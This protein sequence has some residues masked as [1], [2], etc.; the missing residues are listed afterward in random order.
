[1]FS[2]ALAVSAWGA[3]VRDLSGFMGHAQR[4][5]FYLSPTLYG[6]ELVQERFGKGA[7]AGSGLVAYLPEKTRVQMAQAE[8]AEAAAA[9]A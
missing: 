5:L 1:M 4:I 8:A 3:L 6:V 9:T 7:L 2:V